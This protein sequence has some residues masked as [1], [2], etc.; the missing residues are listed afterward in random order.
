MFKSLKTHS[1]GSGN[2]IYNP[3]DVIPCVKLL[4]FQSYAILAVRRS[5]RSYEL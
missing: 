1:H 2:H 3:I 5:I 4:L